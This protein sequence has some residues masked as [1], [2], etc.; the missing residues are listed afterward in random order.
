MR[1]RK[2]RPCLWIRRINIVEIAIPPKAIYKFNAIHIKI[3]IQSFTELERTVL[4][5]IKKNKKHQRIV[6]TILNNKRTVGG[7]II[8]DFKSYYKVIAIKTTWY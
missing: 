2:D 1:R 6:N 4:T 8:P 7:I 3:P 5:L